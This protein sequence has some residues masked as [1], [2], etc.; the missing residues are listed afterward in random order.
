MDGEEGL[1]EF[2]VDDLFEEFEEEEEEENNDDD[3]TS[4]DD[5]IDPL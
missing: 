2:D 3:L 4:E 5:L 1:M